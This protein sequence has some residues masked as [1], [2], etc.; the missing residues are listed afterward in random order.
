MLGLNSATYVLVARQSRNLAQQINQAN[1]E[2]GQRILEREKKVGKMMAIIC[3]VFFLVFMLD[4]IVRMIDFDHLRTSSSGHVWTLC[5]KAS[6]A[7]V[8]PM[9]YISCQEQYR[10]EMKNLA[11]Q[12]RSVVSKKSKCKIRRTA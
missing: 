10:E 2:T 8:N 3:I 11:M 6:I 12:W 9:V 7:L 4:P 1:E 5:I